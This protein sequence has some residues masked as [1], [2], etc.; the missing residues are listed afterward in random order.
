[1]RVSPR[2][3]KTYMLKYRL[4][5]GRV[6]WKTIGR[7]GAM[8]LEEARRRAKKDIGL[9]ADG[10]DPL[11]IKDAARDAFTV[12]EVADRFLEDH[13]EARRKPATLRLYQLAIDG[14]VRPKLGAVPVRD[15]TAEDVLKLH[16][17]LRA[18]PY[19]ANRVVAVISKLMNWAATAGYRGPGPHLNPCDGVEKFKEAARKRYL[20][21]QE[22]ARVG[23]ALRVAERR[24]AMS[25]AALTAIRLLLL[26]GARVSEVLGLEWQHVDLTVGVLR[27]PDSKTGAKR[28]LLSPPALELLKAW[29]RWAGTPYVFPG[30]GRGK[31]KG[32]HRVSLVDAWSWIRRRAKIP[33]VRLHDLRHSFASVAV[34]SGQTLP[35]IGALLGHTQAQTTQ[36]YAHLLEDPLRAA[37]DAT[38][39]AIAAAIAARRGR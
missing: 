30:E 3:T 4:A 21:P 33:D 27:L 20:T 14:H 36:R 23:C 19:M 34:S 39:G 16:H 25:P 9:V 13:V 1:M 6:R 8:A 26:T 17:R 24:Q 12:G 15:V 37:G 2:G 38:A 5:S 35:I 10:K 18:T 32:E 31:R 28:I 7:V 11:L 22:L 29:P